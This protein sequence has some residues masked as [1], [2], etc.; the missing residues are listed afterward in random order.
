LFFGENKLRSIGQASRIATP[1]NKKNKNQDPLLEEVG[2]SN[3]KG[4]QKR[5]EDAMST[6]LRICR[7]K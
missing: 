6:K 1:K 2:G 4:K 7:E 5:G 3:G